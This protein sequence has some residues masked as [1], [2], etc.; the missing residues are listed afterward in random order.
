MSLLDEIKD[1][2]TKVGAKCAICRWLDSLPDTDAAE[3]REVFAA[4][5]N[6]APHTAVEKVLNRHGHPFSINQVS[7]HRKQHAWKSA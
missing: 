6:T 7:N 5:T 1:V 4:D 2:R 3:W